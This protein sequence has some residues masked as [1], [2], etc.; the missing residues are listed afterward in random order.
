M[1][2]ILNINKP[3]GMT[4]HD[5]VAR[6]RRLAKQK[7]VGHAGTLDPLATGVLLVCLGQ[8][9]RVAE[10]LTESGKTYRAT[11]RFGIETDTYDAEGAVV[12]EVP[13]A[14][15][16]ADITAVLPEFL[17]EQMQLPPIYSAI[18]RDGQPLYKLARAG[19]DVTVQPR[20][21]VIYAL[22]PVSWQPPDLVLDVDC[23]KGT[24]IRSLAHD[25]G[26][27]LGV[28]A[29]LAALARTRSGAFTLARSVTLDDLA[30]AL[31][32]DGWRDLL[33][34]ADEALL[35]RRAAILGADLE[36]RL[37]N[38]QPLRFPPELRGPAASAPPL[39]DEL[40]RAYATDGRFLGLARWDAVSDAWLP[41]K[42]LAV[43]PLDDT[44]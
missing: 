36:A 31:A 11:V 14:F 7:R 33:Y 16:L 22:T 6:V 25:L 39:P 2:G 27:R 19:E 18:K 3:A 15:D 1:D 35:D 8:A 41:H 29:H 20:P 43:P 44:D 38:G 9:T 13:V 17:G 4:S 42:V 10:Y 21:I 24:Y 26:A 5:V 28:G 40:L 37:R 23:G 34:A 30:V 12:A 32:G